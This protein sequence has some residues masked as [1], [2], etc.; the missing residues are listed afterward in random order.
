MRELPS[1]AVRRCD[2]AASLVGR[3]R[4]RMARDNQWVALAPA[5]LSITNGFTEIGQGFGLVANDIPA[6]FIPGGDIFIDALVAFDQFGKSEIFQLGIRAG[7]A[8]IR[9]GNELFNRLS[10]FWATRQRRV[11]DRL[12]VF[13]SS[14]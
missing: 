7:R 13:K 10:A 1:G 12:P 14:S 2:P 5:R 6:V 3:G 8:D 9:P 4:E 11:M